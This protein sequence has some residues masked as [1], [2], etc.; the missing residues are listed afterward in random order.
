MLQTFKHFSSMHLPR[1]GRTGLPFCRW[2]AHFLNI[3]EEILS[4][5]SSPVPLSGRC[6]VRLLRGASGG[7]PVV[8]STGLGCVYGECVHGGAWL[9]RNACFLLNGFTTVAWIYGLCFQ[10]G[11]ANVGFGRR[12]LGLRD[13]WCPR[14]M[15]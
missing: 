7:S 14:G 2:A 15:A 13:S 8:P 4:P 10:G 3:S 1:A 9:T 12:I 11:V 5:A 6:P